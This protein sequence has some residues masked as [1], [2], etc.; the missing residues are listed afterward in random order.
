MLTEWFV[1]LGTICRLS[2]Y[3]RGKGKGKKKKKWKGKDIR[4][5]KTGMR[6]EK[7]EQLHLAR[8]GNIQP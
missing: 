7:A 2:A 4:K 5:R 6:T 8:N 3:I 1:F